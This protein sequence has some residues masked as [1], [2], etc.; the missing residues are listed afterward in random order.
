MD[1]EKGRQVIETMFREAVDEVMRKVESRG[2]TVETMVSL[3]QCFISKI[4]PFDHGEIACEAG[5]ASCCHLR[6]IVSI[7]EVI[8]IYSALKSS[9]SVD[10]LAGIGRE[11]SRLTGDGQTGDNSWWL[12]TSNSCALLHKGDGIC[13]IYELRPFVCRAYH[14][15]DVKACKAGFEG[16]KEMDIPCFPMLKRWRE[17]YSVA[18]ISGMEKMG[19]HSLPVEFASALNLIFQD[20]GIIEEWFSGEATFQGAGIHRP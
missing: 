4:Q 14:S 18:L 1:S 10:L 16:K 12:S 19:L 9:L 13:S 8:A 7:P 17:L 20:E 2:L 15:L 5:C 6:V 3:Q 11:L